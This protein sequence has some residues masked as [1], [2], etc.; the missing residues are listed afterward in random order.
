M[1]GILKLSSGELLSKLREFSYVLAVYTQ[2]PKRVYYYYF[3]PK[4]FFLS[5]LSSRFLFLQPHR[6][7][8]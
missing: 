2:F 7:G 1:Q 3:K 5:Q 8:W 4:V 6:V